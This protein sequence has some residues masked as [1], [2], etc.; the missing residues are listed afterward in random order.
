MSD[1]APEIAG[2]CHICEKQTRVKLCGVCG[3]H[4][5]WDC[6][7]KAWPWM[8]RIGEGA[9]EQFKGLLGLEKKE[10]RRDGCCGPQEGR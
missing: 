7:N 3:H 4:F 6:R 10:W 9:F 1:D 2:K 5:C 8:Q